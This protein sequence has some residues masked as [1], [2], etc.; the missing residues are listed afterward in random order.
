MYVPPAD[1]AWCV[2]MAA[3]KTENAGHTPSITQVLE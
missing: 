3:H 1:D 2:V